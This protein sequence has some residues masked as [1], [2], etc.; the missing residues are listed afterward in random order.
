M[1]AGVCGLCQKLAYLSAA[2]SRR[3]CVKGN[4]R[5]ASRLPRSILVV[6]E[7]Y[8]NQSL[9]VVEALPRGAA[10]LLRDYHNPERRPLARRLLE[11]CHRRRAHLLFAVANRTDV[12]FAL[13]LGTHGLHLP[14]V[15]LRT[16]AQI[17]GGLLRLPAR[18]IFTVSAHSRAALEKAARLGIHAALLSPVFTT[19][20]HPGRSALGPLRFSLLARGAPL[21][22]YALGG[23]HT[24]NVRRLSQSGAA[25]IA[26]I[27]G[28]VLE[29]PTVPLSSP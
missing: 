12:D 8:R 4:T 10:V 9:T 13:H 29:K 19:T 15:A 14:E 6:D 17:T 16:P 18:R 23:I 24:G 22:V 20:S 21:P 25:G 5:D 3:A 2:L 28:F 26:A 27:E 11:L 7:K 1:T